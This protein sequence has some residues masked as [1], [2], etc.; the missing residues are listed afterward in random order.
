[1][2]LKQVIATLET[3]APLHLA[4]SWDNV[5][6]LVGD[7]AS[8]ISSVM[9]CL[10]ITKD[11]VEEA[12][13]QQVQ[14]IVSHHPVLFKP[15]QRIT[16][17]DDGT[18]LVWQ[19]IRHGVAV[20]SPHTAYDN[21]IGGINDQLAHTLGLTDVHPLV[22]ANVPAQCKI[23]VFVPESHLHEVSQALFRSGAGIIGNYEQCSFRS[24]GL[25]TYWGNLASNPTLGKAGQFETAEEYRLETV[26]PQSKLTEALQALK[27]V[28]PYEEPAVD[29]IPLQSVVYQKIGS[30]RVGRLA[31][32]LTPA[33]LAERVSQLLN[34]PV[35]L[36]GSTARET[37][38]KVAI[39]CGAGGSL[40][41]S[42][43]RAGVH[44]FLTGEIRFHDELAAQVS[45]ITVLA[46]GHFVTERPG[47][48][49]L[50]DRLAK[51]LPDCTVWASRAEHNPGKW[52]TNP[53]IETS[54]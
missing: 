45:D 5:G 50:A 1:M 34:T 9:T 44:A 7:P 28:H 49:Q 11:V 20:Y 48:E 24:E 10:T 40:L 31:V 22:P 42:A 6:L 3:I 54:H 32:P 33:S 18:Q 53:A 26:C 21:A 41:S 25:G 46:A 35:T 2:Q 17:S 14:L 12:I 38:S 30:G 16:T 47:V 29:V 52:V 4:E 27:S 39:V 37:I 13:Q 51:L 8:P 43:R 15:V 19:L 36:T 23:V